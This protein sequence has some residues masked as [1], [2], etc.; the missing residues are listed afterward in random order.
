MSSPERAR[1]GGAA[2][3]PADER[4]AAI[5]AALLAA[6]FP[7]DAV[8]VVAGLPERR[9]DAA[10]ASLV[11]DGTLLTED[12]GRAR[13]ADAAAAARLRADV[14]P[15]A[16][17]RMHARAA[18]ELARR[19]RVAEAAEHALEGDVAGDGELVELLE[20]SG[21]D[22]LRRGA[23]DR[24][25]RVLGA[26]VLARGDEARP[27]LLRGWATALLAAGRAAEAGDAARAALLHPALDLPGRI[28]AL[29]LLGRAEYL[30]GAGDLGATALDRAVELAAD[31][32]RVAAVGA[33]LDHA[34]TGW[35]VAGPARALPY[36]ERAVAMAQD[37]PEALRS[38]ARVS[39]DQVAAECGDHAALRAAVARGVRLEPEPVA[40]SRTTTELVS[41]V[42][43]LYPYAHA[44]QF[45]DLLDESLAALD[46]ALERLVEAG[47]DDAVSMVELFRANHLI[48]RGRLA[49]ALRGADRAR[50]LAG[51]PL[52]VPVAR[53]LRDLVLARRGARQEPV[54]VPTEGVA[55]IVP[56]WH[57][58]A[59]G[60][61]R[62][63]ERDPRAAD[64]FA[65][66][67]RRLADAGVR[68]PNH[69]PWFAQGVEAQ[70]LA[71][72]RDDAGRVT[73]L[74]AELADGHPGVWPAFALALCR[75]RLAEHDGDL[76]GAIAG[77][78][79]ALARLGSVDLPLER[80]VAQL[81]LGAAL[82]RS[83]RPVDARA[84]LSAAL[85]TSEAA[86]AGGLVRLA[87]GELRLA[88]G[89]RRPARDRD[90]I[91]PAELR[92]AR[93]AV[94]GLTNAEIARTLHLS[95][96]TVATHLKHVYAKLG[97][98]GRT[99]LA[100]VGL[101]ADADAVASD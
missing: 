65:R 3:T 11:R 28:D 9:A 83:G 31:H 92:V 10:V 27:E 1:G 19:G 4:L 22:A 88:G 68:E 84:P 8:G 56:L 17:R 24:A 73:A 36:N 37:G 50:Q 13:F 74:L 57:A 38:R 34:T 94:A 66:M 42:A 46:A 35:A 40:S 98:R 18:R 64:A 99:Q 15:T 90:A 79:E 81:A 23:I 25:L 96:N 77:F 16:R 43:D 12:H 60:I 20:R 29:G 53:S 58:W 21:A 54:A 63:E 5:A 47:A 52:A 95:P 78:H 48:R 49:E 45:A 69:T 85:A 67:E 55:W 30:T 7:V 61:A 89:R 26:A 41:P 59:E 72:R 33:L 86:G 70:L 62:L 6:P 97:V 2:P 87:A 14:A 51:T 101:P 80:A 39:R 32:D 76:D 100:A 75:A 93:A 44:A 91:S 71:G 82:R